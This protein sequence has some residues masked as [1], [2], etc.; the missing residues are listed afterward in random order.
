M[1]QSG[2]WNISLYPTSVPSF[3]QIGWPQ[4][5]ATGTLSQTMTLIVQL[6]STK[7]VHFYDKS[8][9]LC[10][11]TT[12]PK[13]NI[14]GYGGKPNS[15]LDTSTA[16][17]LK[18]STWKRGWQ[19][20]SFWNTTFECYRRYCGR[21]HLLCCHVTPLS[22]IVGCPVLKLSSVHCALKR[23]RRGIFSGKFK[24]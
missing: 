16:Q 6:L 17:A 10:H 19:W 7:I 4:L 15:T 20:K 5:L 18:W 8:M 21:R 3:S 23:V 11:I 22:K 12:N 1:S 2:F 9:K 14:F 24:W 13:S